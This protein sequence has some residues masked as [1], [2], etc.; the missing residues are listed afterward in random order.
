[1]RRLIHPE[2]VRKIRSEYSSDRESIVGFL[3]TADPEEGIPL[4]GPFHEMY[5]WKF[6]PNDSSMYR[7]LYTQDKTKIR[8]IDIEKQVE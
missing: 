2:V 4:R 6:Q 3:K 5:L 1:M 8:I 7:V